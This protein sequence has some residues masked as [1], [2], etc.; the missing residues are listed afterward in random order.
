[1]L[2]N[3]T[4]NFQ[5]GN[6]IGNS[7]ASS[8]PG[9][10]TTTPAFGGYRDEAFFRALRGK[11]NVFLSQSGKQGQKHWGAIF[12][13]IGTV[14]GAGLLGTL[15]FAARR[16]VGSAKKAFSWSFLKELPVS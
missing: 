12:G 13:S 5:G 10:S 9:G 14:L 2:P 3:S 8:G 15:M 7:G 6:T 4:T 11:D 1:M 16:R